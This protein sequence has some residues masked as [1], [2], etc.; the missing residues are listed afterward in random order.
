MALARPELAV[1]IPV[2]NEQDIIVEVLESWSYEFRRLD[3]NFQIHVYDDGSRDNS[4]AIITEYA[5]K[6]ENIVVHSKKNAGHGPTILLGYCENSNVEWIF[7]TDSDNEI[8]TEFFETFWEQRDGFD[9]LIG[10]RAGRSSTLSRKFVSSAARILV[11]LFY[12]KGIIDVNCPYRLMRSAAF[13]QTFRKIPPETFAPNV[14][15]SGITCKKKYRVLE[16]P[17]D[18]RRRTTGV[19]SIQKARLLNASIRSLFQTILFRFRMGTK[20]I[21]NE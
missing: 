20:Y 16:I 14:I 6:D 7:Q 13:R 1:I 21:D 11:R 12:G 10:R 17:V 8:A 3:I 19:V 5:T 2:Y 18:S 4:L 15:L 9:L